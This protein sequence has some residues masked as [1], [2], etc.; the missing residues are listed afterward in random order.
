MNTVDFYSITKVI[1]NFGTSSSSTIPSVFYLWTT[2]RLPHGS[3]IYPEVSERKGRRHH[4]GTFA[5]SSIKSISHVAVTQTYAV[6]SAGSM[7]KEERTGGHVSTGELMQVNNRRPRRVFS[8]LTPLSSVSGRRKRS[9]NVKSAVLNICY[10][11]LRRTQRILPTYIFYDI[12]QNDGHHA[13]I[14]LRSRHVAQLL[15]C[16]TSIGPFLRHSRTR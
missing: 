1:R 11:S 2:T 10:Q 13:K 12:W 5:T 7:E 8:R 15:S 16:N 14:N 9:S 4:F 3:L 6:P